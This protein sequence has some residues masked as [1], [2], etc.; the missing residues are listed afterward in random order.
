MVDS[1]IEIAAIFAVQGARVIFVCE[2]RK[3]VQDMLEKAELLAG[4][5]LARS[6]KTNGRE[7]IATKQGGI[8]H[9]LAP[10]STGMRGV[11]ADA[12]F[13]P[14]LVWN[15]EKLAAGLIPCVNGSA[16]FGNRGP[17]MFSTLQRVGGQA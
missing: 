1:G 10:H 2:H 12:I 8:I 14:P 17:V 7:R 13:A 6:W 9:L 5:H 11:S 15:D 4:E 3:E 16:F